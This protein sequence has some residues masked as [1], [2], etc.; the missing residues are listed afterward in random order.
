MRQMRYISDCA[1]LRPRQTPAALP[2]LRLRRRDQLFVSSARALAP[3][4]ARSAAPMFAANPRTSPAAAK[5]L[6][7]PDLRRR[8]DDCEPVR[9]Q[10]VAERRR[11]CTVKK[12]T[13]GASAA[14]PNNFG[15]TRSR[16]VTSCGP[17]QARRAAR[18]RN[19]H[20]C[21][22]TAESN[23][24]S[25]PASA[26]TGDSVGRHN[27]GTSRTV[28]LRQHLPGHHTCCGG[29]HRQLSAAP[30]RPR[31]SWCTSY[32]RA[33]APL[34]ITDHCGVCGASTAA[35]ALAAVVR[36]QRPQRTVVGTVPPFTAAQT[37]TTRARYRPPT[38]RRRHPRHAAISTTRN[39]E[40]QR[41]SR[42]RIKSGSAQPTSSPHRLR[43]TVPAAPLVQRGH[44]D[45]L[46][47]TG[48]LL[49]STSTAQWTLQTPASPPAS[50]PRLHC[51]RQRR[52]LVAPPRPTSPRH[53]QLERLNGPGAHER[54]HRYG[55]VRRRV[56][57]QPRHALCEPAAAPSNSA[58]TASPPTGRCPI[59]LMRQQPSA[60]R[61]S[62]RQPCFALLLVCDG[63]LRLALSVDKFQR[64]HLEQR[65]L[66]RRRY[67]GCRYRTSPPSAAPPTTVCS[68][69]PGAAGTAHQPHRPNRWPTM[70]GFMM[71]PTS[72]TSG[73]PNHRRQSQ[74]FT[75]WVNSVR[76][77]RA[78]S[79]TAQ[80]RLPRSLRRRQRR[81]PWCSRR[82]LGPPSTPPA[83][84]ARR[85]RRRIS[86]AVQRAFLPALWLALSTGALDQRSTTAPSCTTTTWEPVS[87]PWR[88]R[89]S[90]FWAVHRR[91]GALHYL[92][93]HL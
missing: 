62:D 89:A 3:P 87:G 27:C 93:C 58:G 56:R 64:H 52:R 67:Q 85:P 9:L 88:H 5:L 76:P 69:P 81:P 11:L 42:V 26:R 71:A 66:V 74:N 73:S 33:A 36:R 41:K 72:A 82:Q 59:L 23:A 32:E 68:A 35:R 70:T 21:G 16:T 77:S 37:A 4:A 84:S 79:T 60:L 8:R 65:D 10:T 63:R 54:A 61:V 83:S 38:S 49:L 13:A 14:Q 53:Q 80:A 17:A 25:A 15:T 28:S 57:R 24:H 55:K 47:L 90:N 22:C 75:S 18:R 91:S 78:S 31:R 92:P 45:D 43:A 51:T 46:V 39:L 1:L 6:R 48:T 12:Q 19:H 44:S 34:P 50:H 29:G 20:L 30:P 40:R 7:L 86:I 2:A